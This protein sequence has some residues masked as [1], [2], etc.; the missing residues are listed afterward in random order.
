MTREKGKALLLTLHLQPYI[1]CFSVFFSPSPFS[2]NYRCQF[3]CIF[4]LMKSAVVNLYAEPPF[5]VLKITQ[6]TEIFSL[7]RC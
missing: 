3:K 4:F 7:Q 5:F 1:Y 6:L 2:S